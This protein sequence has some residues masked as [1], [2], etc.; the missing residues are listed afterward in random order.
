MGKLQPEKRKAVNR[1]VRNQKVNGG[2]RQRRYE[3]EA[4]GGLNRRN[5]GKI[6]LRTPDLSG[7]E[8]ALRFS[9]RLLFAE[10]SQFSFSHFN[11]PLPFALPRS[12]CHA[13][14]MWCGLSDLVMVGDSEAAGNDGKI[15]QKN[16]R[17]IWSDSPD[18]VDH[19]SIFILFFPIYFDLLLIISLQP[20]SIALHLLRRSHSPRSTGGV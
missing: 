6:L 9:I 11:F 5:S 19:V 16:K 3:G 15:N 17:K 18:H 8:S 4:G 12:R 7:S 2:V 10:L 13:R 14:L 1:K 20:F